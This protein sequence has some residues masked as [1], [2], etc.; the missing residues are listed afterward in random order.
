LVHL[1]ILD[2]D[3]SLRLQPLLLRQFQPLVY[4]L[5]WW[6]SRLRL[7]CGFGR[8][9]EFEKALAAVLGSSVDAEPALTF[10]GSGD[11]HHVTLALLRRIEQPFNLLVVDNH[12]DWMRGIPFLH[13]GTWVYH[14]AQ[15]PQVQRIYHVGGDVDFDNRFRWLAPWRCLRGGKIRV[16][17]GKRRFK[18]GWWN[19]LACP[20]L[21][22][23]NSAVA[24]ARHVQ[25]LLEPFRDDIGRWPLY[26][27]LDKDVMTTNDAVVNWDSGHLTLPE[28]ETVLAAFTEAAHGRMAGMDILGDWSPVRLQGLG[29][30]LLHLTE[31]PGLH[32]LP[33][34]AARC[35]QRTNVELLMRMSKVLSRPPAVR[36]GT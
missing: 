12:P 35:N 21:R 29:R 25:Q 17:S 6:G 23:P 32:V 9:K 4:D 10:L 13:C 2:L 24:S 22:P 20:A 3:G 31:H 28:V 33:Q 11:F 15:L 7:A 5:R 26:V 27:S 30:H 1:R 8:F 18:R 14:A 19:E 36:V 34:Q 16:I